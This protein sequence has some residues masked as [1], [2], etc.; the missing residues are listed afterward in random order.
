MLPISHARLPTASRL[1]NDAENIRKSGAAPIHVGE[2]AHLFL[3]E[4][5]RNFDVVSD[6][7]PE[8]VSQIARPAL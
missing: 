3:H 7:L 4:V 1:R 8:M 5:R 2:V 6:A